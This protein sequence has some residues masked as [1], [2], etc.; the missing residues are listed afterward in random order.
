[1]HAQVQLWLTKPARI[2]LTPPSPH[3]SRW[4]ACCLPV[5]PASEPTPGPPFFPLAS[6]KWRC[7]R[8]T[9]HCTDGR[10]NNCVHPHIATNF[11]TTSLPFRPILLFDLRQMEPEMV[12]EM[13]R[14]VLLR[15]WPMEP[16][17]AREMVREIVRAVQCRRTCW[18]QLLRRLWGE[19][20]PRSSWSTHWSHAQYGSSPTRPTSF[21]SYS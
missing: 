18:S 2:T 16:E 6:A 9:I 11:S 3:N 7:R 14:G 19:L 13:V 20:R 1:L 12:R 4:G 10:S 8:A 15:K 17:M 21:P 5:S